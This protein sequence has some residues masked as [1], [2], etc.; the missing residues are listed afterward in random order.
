MTLINPRPQTGGTMSPGHV[1]I[2][3]NHTR[4]L[5]TVCQLRAHIGES[6]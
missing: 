2:V 3:N 6:Q 4:E 5:V 1:D